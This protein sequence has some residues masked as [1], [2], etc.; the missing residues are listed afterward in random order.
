[1]P[2]WDVIGLKSKA[3]D[4]ERE[5]NATFPVDP[6]RANA[7]LKTLF[8][9]LG[10]NS[11]VFPTLSVEF[12]FN[13]EIGDHTLVNMN[14]TLMDC[15]KIS[16][17]D[18]VLVGP[19]TLFFAAGHALNASER[20]MRNP[21]TGAD[22]GTIVTGAPIRVENE[23]RIGGGSIVLAGVTVGALTTIGAGSVVTRSIPSGVLAVG[24]PCRV[25]RRLD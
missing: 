23:V 3:K 25:I 22:D 16:L 13:T 7:V 10:D 5:F 21:L 15:F 11:W 8:A 9:K 19:S 24:N 14:C 2:D 12:G 18:R 1:M 6:A 20:M 17:G 4:L